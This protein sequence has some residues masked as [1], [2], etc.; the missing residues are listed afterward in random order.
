MAKRHD[1]ARN[2]I[3]V[4]IERYEAGA[5]DEDTAVADLIQEDEARI[6][7]LERLGGR[8]ALALA[9][10]VL[11]GT[12]GHPPGHPTWLLAEADRTAAGVTDRWVKSRTLVA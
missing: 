5:F 11:G 2:L 7:A 12:P 3:H 4:W 6:A 1:L 9:Y 8:Q 10:G